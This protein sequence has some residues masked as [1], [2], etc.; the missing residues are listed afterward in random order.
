MVKA[1]LSLFS[2]CAKS[3]VHIPLVPI[4]RIMITDYTTKLI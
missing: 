1:K 2:F 3:E 4:L